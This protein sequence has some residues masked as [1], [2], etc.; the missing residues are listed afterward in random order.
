MFPKLGAALPVSQLGGL[1]LTHGERHGE[2]WQGSIQDWRITLIIASYHSFFNNMYTFLRPRR[3]GFAPNL[4]VE[5]HKLLPSI[6]CDNYWNY[7]SRITASSLG[8]RALH[9]SDTDGSLIVFEVRFIFQCYLDP[10][11]RMAQNQFRQE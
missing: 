11:S 3:T 6:S 7:F 9:P 1:A 5:L 8:A 2:R 4:S 10:I